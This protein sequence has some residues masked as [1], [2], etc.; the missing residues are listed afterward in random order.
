MRKG[1]KL[2]PL[3]LMAAL[4]VLLLLP[5]GDST[6]VPVASADVES[7][8]VSSNTM[9]SGGF[10]DITVIFTKDD[11]ATTSLIARVEVTPVSGITG[12]SLQGCTV[13]SASD[14]TF[15]SACA[16]S[17]SDS[18]ASVHE[19]QL[20]AATV[21]ALDGNGTN[22]KFKLVLRLTA[23]CNSITYDITAS[24]DGDQDVDS[25]AIICTAGTTT[26]T[27]TTTPA[28]ATA[29]ATPGVPAS[30][31]G[32]A[33]P[34]TVSC[35]GSAFVT[36]VFRTATGAPVANGTQVNL[37]ASIGTIS[38][39]VTV[40]N[41]GNGGFLA[42]YTAPSN[43]GGTA[44]LTAVAGGV[45]AT[46]QI[47]VNCAVSTP[48]PTATPAP[49]PTLPPASGITPPATGDAGL[50]AGLPAWRFYGGLALIAAALAGTLAVLRG[51][52]A[53]RR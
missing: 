26:P 25:D 24:Q 13:D 49:P 42:V 33:A 8:A 6:R 3:A 27:A 15:A 45:T 29:T 51:W 40:I 10:V 21:A 31:Q 46:T 9:F 53:E 37:S 48:A 47:A 44:T 35:N 4:G 39:A 32:S 41:D 36:F 5:G 23:E 18:D 34:N 43:Q 17:P 19:F 50:A 22:H 1:L 38:P 20:D 16:G 28:T 12:L 30:G 11:V 7:I 52:A 2:V 14:N